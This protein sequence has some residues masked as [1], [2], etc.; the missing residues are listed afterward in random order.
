[1]RVLKLYFANLSYTEPVL[2]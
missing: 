2:K 1:M